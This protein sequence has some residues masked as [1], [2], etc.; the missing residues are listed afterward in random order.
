MRR[1]AVFFTFVLG[2]V[3]CGSDPDTGVDEPATSTTIPTP[4]TPATPA[5]VPTLQPPSTRPGD[6][7]ETP[8]EARDQVAFDRALSRRHIECPVGSACMDLE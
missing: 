3:A 4:A 1:S 2:A 7:T 5:P 8:D 6:L